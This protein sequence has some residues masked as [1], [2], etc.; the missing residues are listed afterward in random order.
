M[1]ERKLMNEN[2]STTKVMK[3]GK[4]LKENHIFTKYDVYDVK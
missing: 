1:K 4:Y 3:N 2:K